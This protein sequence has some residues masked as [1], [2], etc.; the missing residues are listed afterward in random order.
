MS[1][2]DETL[3]NGYHQRLEI[4]R[5]LFEQKTGHQNLILFENPYLGRV[6]AL[7][8]IVQVTERDEFIYH[9]MLVHV[10]LLAHGAAK[11]VLIIGGGDGGSIREVLRHPVETVTLVELDL[12][13][14]DLCRE[15]MPGLSDGAFDDPR[16]DLVIG[17]GVA[18]VAGADRKFDV[19]IVDS[20]DPIGPGEVLFTERFYRD[21]KGCL[22]HGGVLVAQNGVPFFQADEVRTTWRRLAPLFS[23]VGFYTVPVPTYVG[24]LMTLA[25]ATD[26]GGL[27]RVPVDELAQRVSALEFEARYY[28]PEIHT[29]AFSLPGYISDLMG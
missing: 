16:T 25:W 10:P 1:W 2:F 3:I 7:D 12:T 15:H 23:D 26:D 17:D 4:T 24:G 22:G 19:I 11:K 28:T 27:R 29:A 6:L 20:T 13:V 5:V 9:E 8:G 18:F 21:C 14:I